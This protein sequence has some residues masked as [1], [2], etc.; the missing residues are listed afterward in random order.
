MGF[1]N[2]LNKNINLF[3]ILFSMIIL[4]IIIYFIYKVI[5][6]KIFSNKL[7]GLIFDEENKNFLLKYINYQEP[8]TLKQ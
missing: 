1:F 3:L 2:F 6:E 8:L 7:K 4:F 5:K